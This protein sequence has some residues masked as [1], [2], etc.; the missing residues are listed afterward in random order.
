MADH[1]QS[2]TLV[3]EKEDIMHPTP[4]EKKG[5]ILHYIPCY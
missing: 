4:L 1:H 3:Q 2:D 5:Q